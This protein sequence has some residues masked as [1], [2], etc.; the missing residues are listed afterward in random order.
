METHKYTNED[1]LQI[2]NLVYEYKD[3]SSEAIEI[4]LQKFDRFFI[5]YAKMIKYGKYNINNYSTTAFVKLFVENSYE[6][7]LINPY[8][9]MKKGTGKEVIGTTINT[10]MNI[11]STST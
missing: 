8:Y 10:I 11:F 7:R 6:R 2:H 4:L 1:Y 5:N 3:G 9:Y